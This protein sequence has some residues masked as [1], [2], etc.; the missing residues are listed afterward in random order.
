[1]GCGGQQGGKEEHLVALSSTLAVK[2]FSGFVPC[3]GMDLV[4]F[5]MRVHGA[6]NDT[7]QVQPVVQFAAV[8]TDKPDAPILKGSLQSPTSGSLELNTGDI[9]LATDG[10]SKFYVRFGVAYRFN[11]TG[12]S[13]CEADVGLDVLFSQCGQVVGAATH[14]L[15]ASTT[16]DRFAIV[17]GL[18]PV[19]NVD[20]VKAAVIVS[21]KTGNFQ[22]K[23]TYRTFSSNKE[24]PSA[25]QNAFEGSWRTAAGDVNTGELTITGL[26]QVAW[27]Q[28]AIQYSSSSGAGQANVAA[29]VGVRK[30]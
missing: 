22:W 18:V 30:A 24:T 9:S 17:G 2:W 8:R 26:G 6:S 11:P 15:F 3:I 29:A 19:M 13:Q 20:K 1:M 25:W 21:S 7:L 28:F 12:G 27:I 14:D 23:I 4:R 16:D 5:V 10:A